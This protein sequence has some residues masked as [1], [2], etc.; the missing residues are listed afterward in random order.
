VTRPGFNAGLNLGRAFYRSSLRR[1][2]DETSRGRRSAQGR[3][4]PC[5]PVLPAS[6]GGGGPMNRSRP[7]RHA[8]V[9]VVCVA[10]ASV[11]L[12][13]ATAADDGAAAAVVWGRR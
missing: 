12:G 4:G 5:D 7:G 2:Q 13:A 9:A 1:G 10:A 8:V 11:T 6:V 3:C